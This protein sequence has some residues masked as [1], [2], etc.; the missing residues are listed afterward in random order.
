MKVIKLGGASVKDAVSVQNAAL[1]VKSYNN[2]PLVVVLSA[3]GKMTNAFEKLAG[4]WFHNEKI[5]MWEQRLYIRDYHKNILFGLIPSDDHCAHKAL[6]KLFTEIDEI[7]EQLPCESYDECYGK[8]IPYGELVSSCIFSNWLLEQS[9]LHRLADASALICT[10]SHFREAEVCW[11]K[12]TEAVRSAWQDAKTDAGDNSCL[13]LTQGFIGSDQHQR[14]TTLGREGSDYTAA[15]IAYA[16]DA[17]EVIIWKDVPGLMN[18][19]PKV[20]PDTV[21][22]HRL[23]YNDAIELAYYGATVIHPKTIK[24]LQNKQIPLF[25]KSFHNPFDPGTYIGPDSGKYDPVPCFIY[26][27]QQILLSI[28]PHDF[29]FINEEK[30]VIILNIFSRYGVR[31]NMMENSAISFSVC[32]DNNRPDFSGMIT[33]LQQHFLVKYN[34]GLELFTIRNY[35]DASILRVTH[36]RKIILEQRSRS[37]ARFLMQQ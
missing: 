4:H 31:I 24:P 12:T 7:I 34:Q 15:I 22:L 25:V 5:Q 23:S 28:I 32:F 6:E 27:P 26:K 14:R 20:F 9:I 16:I 18:A 36:N 19:D 29:S 13:L 3:M 2:H 8:L 37:T 21:K 1:I 17:E 11:N 10:S 35:D 33:Q 30:L